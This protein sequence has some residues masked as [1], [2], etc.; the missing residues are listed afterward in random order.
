MFSRPLER[1]LIHDQDKI[2]KDFPVMFE[3]LGTLSKRKF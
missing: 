2:K 1:S 3:Y